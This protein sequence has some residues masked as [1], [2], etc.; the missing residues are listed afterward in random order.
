M[1][2]FHSYGPV[3]KEIHFC[4]ERTEIVNS[5]MDQMIGQPNKGG[6]YFTLWAPRQTGKTWLMREVTQLIEHAYPD[7]FIIGM[8]SMQGI[9]MQESEPPD[10]FLKRIPRLMRQNLSVDVPQQDSWE[11]LQP[12][13]SYRQRQGRYSY[14][15]QRKEEH[16][17]GQKLCGYV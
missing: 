5:C 13:V 1:R 11:G 16:H 2:R 8:M 7:Q 14:P 9:I 17:R 4:A 15:V 3:D 12:G 10:A 6:H